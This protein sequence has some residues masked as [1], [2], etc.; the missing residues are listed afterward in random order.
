MQ[1]V[2]RLFF[3]S[4]MNYINLSLFIIIAIAMMSIFFSFWISEKADNDAKAIN[5]SGTMRMQM[6][7]IG[8]SLFSSP[9]KSLSMIENLDRTW[10]DSLFT[11]LRAEMG[12]ERLNDKFLNAHYSWQNETKPAL[13]MA[14]SSND[15]Q[16]NLF[17]LIDRQVLMTDELVDEFQN[18]AEQKIKELRTIQFIALIITTLIGS[19]IFYLLR[20]RIEVPL[21]SLTEAAKKISQGEL[22]QKIPETGHDELS[23]LAKA[24]NQ[25]SASIKHTW[26]E[27]E[28]L[29]DERTYELQRNNTIVTFLYET[30][31]ATIDTENQ[32]LDY[33]KI[34][35]K[36][37]NI[38]ED[39]EVEICFFTTGGNTPY[40]QISSNT[41]KDPCEANNCEVCLSDNQ[42]CTQTI[43]MKHHYPIE[44][45]E[46]QYGV[47]TVQRQTPSVIEPWQDKLLKSCADQIAIAFSLS[48]NMN[49]EYRLAMLRE[50][51]V[52]ARELHDSLAQ[53]LS[54]LQIQVTRLQKAQ[55]KGRSDLQETIMTE[56]REGL[57]SAYRHLREL[58]TTFRLKLDEDG[59]EGAL[60]LAREQLSGQTEMEI[61]LNYEIKGTPLSANEEIH[62]LQ[63]VREAAQNAINHSGGKHLNITLRNLEDHS[64][65]VQIEDDGKG[66]PENP[67]KLNH[68]GLAIMQERSK[69]LDGDN[70]INNAP[71]TGVRIALRFTPAY[72]KNAA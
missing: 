68:Y 49:Q 24:F 71:E 2:K 14:I 52:I 66:L 51:T 10:E 4:V 25:M 18:V 41:F 62:L 26:N 53:S 64:I 72:I 12:S 31:Q 15:A 3:Q 33:P 58:L 57:S 7:Q 61:S 17:N 20:N 44:Y 28:A 55:D 59:L 40:Q 36:L 16:T 43:A 34:T 5:L 48:D 42:D 54:Y 46:Q 56:L 27:L 13:L 65:E 8:M 19:I 63:I 11:N 47:F 30:A 67:E 45:Q 50:R 1:K 70:Y 6:Y 35:S 32:Q 38:L 23:D 69:Q 21:K 29:V 60:K 39:C 22:D 37:S 9:E